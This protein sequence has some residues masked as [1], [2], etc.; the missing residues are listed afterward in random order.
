MA[1]RAGVVALVLQR[2]AQRI[3]EVQPVDL[4]QVRPRQL[5]AH[6][7]NLGGLEGGDLQVG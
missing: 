7:L 4:R 2:L 3:V 1:E 5:G 6:G